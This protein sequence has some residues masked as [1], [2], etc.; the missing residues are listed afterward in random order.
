MRSRKREVAS[1]AGGGADFGLV[2]ARPPL[3]EDAGGTAGGGAL[4]LADARRC[5]PNQ[6]T[7]LGYRVREA[8]APTTAPTCPPLMT[9]VS[10]E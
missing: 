5:S 3:P 6:D 9:N 8:F 7:S 4:T 2:R 10:F 1:Q